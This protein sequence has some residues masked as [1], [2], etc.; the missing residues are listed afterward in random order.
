MGNLEF[1]RYYRRQLP[2][3]QLPGATLFVTFRL[4]G[5]IPSG[6]L[7]EIKEESERRIRELESIT[8][9]AE[10]AREALEFSRYLFGEWESHLDSG[11]EG[12]DYLRNPQIADMVSESL[13]YRDGKVYTLEAYCIMP[14][15]VH[16]VCAPLEEDGSFFSIAAIMHSLK[17][18]TARKANQLLNRTGQFWQHENY[19][20]LVRD[21]AEFGRIIYYVVQNP[22]KVGL[23][24][25][26]R[27]WEWTYC[28]Y[29]L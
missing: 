3:L 4:A 10:C 1:K 8:D 6:I 15:H 13:R 12:P 9:P 5:S 29:D 20:H 23:V 24:D 21:E 2:H 25:H 11:R 19:D 22:V 17:R 14:N 28:R 16:L 7:R 27:D 26:W 18:F